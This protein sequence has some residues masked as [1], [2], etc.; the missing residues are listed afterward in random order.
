LQVRGR[1]SAANMEKA[2]GVEWAEFLQFEIAFRV[3]DY[4]IV[5]AENLENELIF[6]DFEGLLSLA[7]IIGLL[8][9]P[10]AGET[11]GVIGK[12]SGGSERCHRDGEIEK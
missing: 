3:Q 8:D 10:L 9:G 5:G 6:F 7:L 1:L 12:K 11:F 2:D 4:L